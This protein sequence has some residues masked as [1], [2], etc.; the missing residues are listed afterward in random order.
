MEALYCIV[1]LLRFGRGYVARLY[2][3]DD[4]YDDSGGDGD[5]ACEHFTNEQIHES[6]SL[7]VYVYSFILLQ[8]IYGSFGQK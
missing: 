2:D 6:F 3:D 7:S 5:I 8:F 1:W 4:D